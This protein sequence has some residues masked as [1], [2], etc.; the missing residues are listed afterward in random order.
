MADNLTIQIGADTSK[1]RADL[2]LAQTEVRKLGRELT[3]AAREAQRTGDRGALDQL[4]RQLDGATR[5]A[6]T[7]RR[8]LAQ[9]NSVAAAAGREMAGLS[10]AVAGVGRAFMS[11]KTLLP[12]AGLAGAAMGVANAVRSVTENLIDLRNTSAATGLKPIDVQA[13]TEF[14]E[15]ASVKTDDARKMLV[16][17][18]DRVADTRQKLGEL[19]KS[20]FGVNVMRGAEG[21]A[22]S[23]NVLR[24]AVQ[25]AT[26]SVNV[27]RGGVQ[28]IVDIKDPFGTLKLDPAK[29]K[30]TV[31]LL[32]EFSKRLVNVKDE[33]LRT[34]LGVEVWGRQYGQIAI[35]LERIAKS[36]AW[37]QMRQELIATG[38]AVDDNAI[39][40]LTEYEKAWK[41]LGDAIQSIVQPLVISTF[42]TLAAVI[43][44]L[45]TGLTNFKEALLILGR[46]IGALFDAI[47]KK[48]SATFNWLI[49]AAK[50]VASAIPGGS[51]A[52]EAAIPPPPVTYASGGWVRGAGTGTSDSILAR[53]S[54]GEFV[55]RA[56][57]VRHWGAGLLAA[58]NSAGLP[59]FA[60]GGL[61]GAAGGGQPVHLHIGGN[62][63][64]LNGA[65][66]VVSALV[67]EAHRQHVRSAGVKPSWYGGR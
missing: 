48:A 62:S 16:R 34:A 66:A 17:F 67:V 9:H 28:K 29:F 12:A 49:G 2:A 6:A 13:F 52:A 35:V 27:F 50:A 55:M 1:L 65:P 19:G 23:V 25:D 30:S 33:Q 59:R 64:P 47:T 11:L 21:A 22:S 7:L 46:D 14:M 8:E 57:A 37:E 24:G 15:D 45:S 58:M 31:D 60:E 61:V 56:A 42:P 43:R 41:D 63:F 18:V 44:N 32:V 36:G 40:P 26:S 51:P 4:A 10:T 53:L 54:N 20:D 38:R 39:K 3:A 5:S